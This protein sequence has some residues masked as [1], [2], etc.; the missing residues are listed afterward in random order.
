MLFIPPLE[1]AAHI[2]TLIQESE[3]KLIIVSP[4]VN[5]SDWAKMVKCLEKAISRGVE[6]IFIARRNAKQDL[7]VFKNIGINPILIDDLHAK[8]YINDNYGIVTSLNLVHYSDINSID[9]AYK[10]DNE[11]EKEE[12]LRF[13]NKYVLNS[14]SVQESK[15]SK[16]TLITTENQIRFNEHQV[17]QI[18]ESFCSKFWRCNI[19]K[20]ST[21]IFCSALLPF[22]DVMVDSRLTIRI[23]KQRTDFD[24]IIK[25]IETIHFPSFH[26]FSIELKLNSQNSYHYIDFVPTRTIELQKLIADYLNVVDLI[27]NSSIHNVLK[28][29]NSFW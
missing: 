28:K 29:Q 17:N 24:E 16:V 1:I 14:K 15:T 13:V 27:L 11:V 2:M 18:F 3:R 26:D 6:V 25:F 12:L 19:N 21:Y 4:Y 20:T 23:S 22:A 8:V 10:T 7:S 5:L 9:I